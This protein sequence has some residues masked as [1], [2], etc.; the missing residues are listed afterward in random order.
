M[1]VV[2][3]QR[4]SRQRRRLMLCFCNTKSRNLH[5]LL[6]IFGV[7]LDCKQIRMYKDVFALQE[8][9]FV[10]WLLDPFCTYFAF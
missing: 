9:G 8:T 5:K 6:N 4:P 7:R 1:L 10:P 2:C 3:G